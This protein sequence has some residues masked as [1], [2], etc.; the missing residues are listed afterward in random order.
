V[1][2]KR[3]KWWVAILI[4]AGSVASAGAADFSTLTGPYLGQEPP[5]LQPQPFTEGLIGFSHSSISMSPDGTEIYWAERTRDQRT[6]RIFFT[7][8]SADGWGEPTPLFAGEVTGADCPVVSPDGRFLFFNSVHPLVAGEQERERLWVSERKESGWSAPRPLSETVNA[9][10]LHW[11]SSVDVDGNLY[12]GAVPATGGT[13]DD[14]FVSYWQDGRFQTPRRMTIS[15]PLDE[16]TPFIDPRGEYVLVSRIDGAAGHIAASFRGEDGAWT[17][18]VVLDLGD[19]SYPVC[20]YVSPDGKYLFFLSRAK[21]YWV[22]AEVIEA[23][24]IEQGTANP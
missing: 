18:P 20:P 9:F 13:D 22:D 12:F 7:Q 16:T 8:R 2:A 10:G 3:F 1:K 21:V 23:A 19:A 17:E 11:Q 6:S 4:V 14:I 15:T 24:R 5:G